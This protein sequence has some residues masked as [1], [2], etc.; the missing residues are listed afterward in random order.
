M[1]D[2]MS[3]A[4]ALPAIAGNL[5]VDPFGTVRALSVLAARATAKPGANR[6]A[7]LEALMECGIHPISVALGMIDRPKGDRGHFVSFQP[8][9][10][11]AKRLGVDLGSAHLHHVNP[12]GYLWLH[13]TDPAGRVDWPEGLSIIPTS[14][15]LPGYSQGGKSVVLPDG[16]RV[17][18][19][20]FADHMIFRNLPPGLVVRGNLCVERCLRW[21]GLIP[22]DAVIGGRVI[23]DDFPKSV[24]MGL[25]NRS[26][27]SGVTLETWR[28]FH[29]ALPSALSAG[30]TRSELAYRLWADEVGYRADGGDAP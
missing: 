12:Q 22:D 13:G 15:S 27:P 11:L 8:V 14:L 16:L 5:D 20:V 17:D 21:D 3:W 23:C 1:L 10:G 2:M 29:A 30:M 26:Y 4:E 19:H 24:Q 6:V 9:R 18:G 7:F 25:K 28:D